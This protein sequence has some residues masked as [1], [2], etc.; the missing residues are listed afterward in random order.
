VSFHAPSETIRV[1]APT[2][3][4]AVDLARRLCGLHTYLVQLGDRGWHVCVRCDGPA[5]ELVPTVRDAAEAWARDRN[6]DAVLRVGE[7]AREIAH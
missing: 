1:E 5:E 6:F 7:N 2:R 3:W 4:D